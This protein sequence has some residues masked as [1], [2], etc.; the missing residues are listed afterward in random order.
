MRSLWPLARWR[1]SAICRPSGGRPSDKFMRIF[2]DSPYDVLNVGTIAGG[3]ASNIIAE[4]C[5]F[6]ITYRSLPDAESLEIYREGRAPARRARS[7]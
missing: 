5:S 7:L 6:T 4:E 2:P 1:R 3:I